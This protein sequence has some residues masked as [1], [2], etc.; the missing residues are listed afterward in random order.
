MGWS[1]GK[2]EAR[3]GASGQTIYKDKFGS[4]LASLLVADYRMDGE[5]EVGRQLIKETKLSF[6]LLRLLCCLLQLICC[7]ED[8]EIRGYLPSMEG[9]G[10]NLMEVNKDEELLAELSQKKTELL[11]ELENYERNLRLVNKQGDDLGK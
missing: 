6:T 11:Y 10:G 7:S 4:Q 9:A 3:D 5:E 8:G 2:F 1:N